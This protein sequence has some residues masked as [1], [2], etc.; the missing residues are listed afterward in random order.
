MD[1]FDAEASG[2]A[3]DDSGAIM[4]GTFGFGFSRRSL[5]AG[6][7]MLA[8]LALV[9]AAWGSANKGSSPATTAASGATTSAAGG[10]AT[11]ASGASTSAGPAPQAKA[12]TLTLGVPSLEEQYVDPH[13]PV[14]GLI[15]PLTW[16]ISEGL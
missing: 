4:P 1:E 14:G 7:G 13:F 8:L 10:A 11:S 6:S 15:F 12:D 3:G 16:A 5:L 2:A 9:A